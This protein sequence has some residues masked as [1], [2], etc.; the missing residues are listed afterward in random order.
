M[1]FTQK[2]NGKKRYILGGSVGGGLTIWLINIIMGLNTAVAVNTTTNEAQAEEI[3]RVKETPTEIAKVQKDVEAI[4][5]KM[6][7]VKENIG[8]LDTE[9]RAMRKDMNTGFKE[10]NGEM[11]KGF[12]A[13]MQEIKKAQ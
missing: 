7:E 3:K 2:V 9:Q 6:T 1:T 8:K 13:V 4:N 11:S 10:V 5:G 12:M